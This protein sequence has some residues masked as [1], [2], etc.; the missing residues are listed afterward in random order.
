MIA[1]VYAA[2]KH[3]LAPG[4]YLVSDSLFIAGMALLVMGAV[5]A[6][7]NSGL[8]DLTRHGFRVYRD[9]ILNRERRTDAQGESGMHA[10]L[11]KPKKDIRYSIIGGLLCI[12]A[13]VAAGA[14][15]L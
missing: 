11:R 9:L 8:F 5:N 15:S 3:K 10:E 4:A 14:A 7:H 2:L 1:L 12:I 6:V 13:S